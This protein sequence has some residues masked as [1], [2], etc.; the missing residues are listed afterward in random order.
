[1]RAR[2]GCEGIGPFVGATQPRNELVFEPLCGSIVR[3]E[4]LRPIVI[5]T[6]SIDAR[7]TA[8]PNNVPFSTLS[9]ISCVT[10]CLRKGR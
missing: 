3:F 9:Y 10:D 4:S 7:K 6:D 5:L 2:K 8:L 1:M